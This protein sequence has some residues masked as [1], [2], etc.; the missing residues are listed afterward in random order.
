[1]DSITNA[2]SGFQGKLRAP[3]QTIAGATAVICAFAAIGPLATNIFL[4]SL[5]AIANDLHVSSAQ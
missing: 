1:M 4:P 3:A 2:D 5:P